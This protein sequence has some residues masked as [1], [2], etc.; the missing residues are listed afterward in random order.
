MYAPHAPRSA[1]WITY[2]IFFVICI[3]IARL[4]YLQIYLNHLLHAQSERNYLRTEYIKP[5]RGN[6]RDIN[7]KLLATNQP[8]I[9]VQWYG[10]GQ[11]RLTQEQRNTL[12]ELS[13][14]LDIP[15]HTESEKH[16]DICRAERWGKT[17]TLAR[18]ISFEQ[19]SKIKEQFPLNQ[20]ISLCFDFKRYYPYK[21]Y[22]CHLL[23]YLGSLDVQLVGKMGLEKLFHDRLEGEYGQII[24]TIN[25]TG[26]SLAQKELKKALSGIDIQT[27]IDIDIQSIAE[28]VFPHDR[29]GTFIIMDPANGYINA[30][31]S[32][33]NFDPSIFLNPISADEWNA[34][35]EERPFINRAFN[36]EYPPGSIFKLIST[37]A[38]LEEGLIEPDTTWN[39][40]GYVWCGKRKFWCNRRF[41]H[42]EI[43]TLESLAQ[44]CNTMFY[45]VGKKL[46]ID[47]IADY[48]QRFGLS[49]KTGIMLREKT[50]FIPTRSWKRTMKGEPWWLGETLSVMIGQSYLLATPI[51]IAR[52]IGS[53][54]TGTLV[55]P[56]ILA[57]EPINTMPLE[58]KESTRAFLKK[59]MKKVVTKGTGRRLK[60]LSDITIYAKTSTAQTSSLEKRKL[61]EKHLEHGWFVGY[62]MYKGQSP[63]VIVVLAEH[64][65]SARV[66]TS[67]AK[68]F[69]VEYKK[70]IDRIYPTPQINAF[71]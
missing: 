55:T 7:G 14:I 64:A 9:H 31:V 21:K 5:Q 42:N 70:H 10:T 16:S 63:R 32:R 12:E 69:F 37:A 36:A 18:E 46:D 38:A 68:D 50:G 26:K 1:A 29:S 71:A 45:Q 23:G 44:S 2:A 54:F 40:K 48:A 43:S 35:Q 52:M 53:I 57:Q 41:G 66:P 6:I 25:S 17:C 3:I 34:L 56:H 47:T 58:L 62:F 11:Y 59:S 61:G 39:C 67:I 8:T 60:Q 49:K 28:T 15:L 24:K 27:T 22:A 51:Q 13:A 33:P 19:L 65:G 30:L 20:N 4:S